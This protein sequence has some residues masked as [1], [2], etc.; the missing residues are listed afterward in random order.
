MW[1]WDD[2]HES[3]N[4]TVPFASL[5]ESIWAAR[6]ILGRSADA[7]RADVTARTRH[8]EITV[9]LSPPD[10]YSPE[11]DELVQAPDVYRART[12]A[13][14]AT[15]TLQLAEELDRLGL[16]VSP[17]SL[18][19]TG[20]EARIAGT[21]REGIR[22]MPPTW[23]REREAVSVVGLEGGTYVLERGRRVERFCDHRSGEPIAPVPLLV[24]E[25][26]W[27]HGTEIDVAQ[28]TEAD[29]AALAGARS[30]V[31]LVGFL[32]LELQYGALDPARAR[33]RLLRGWLEARD[34]LSIEAGPVAV[35]NSQRLITRRR[36]EVAWTPWSEDPRL[37][38]AEPSE[39]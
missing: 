2:L 16:V 3:A 13:A 5:R 23:R 4:A 32:A 21:R 24:G 39:A 37:L 1:I 27:M 31:D 38:L 28:V 8:L 20:T 25:T 17:E 34:A 11:W 30:A 7:V 19:D 33:A 35:A 10:S 18:R 9:E 6:A 26:Y 14:L 29:V 15:A 36:G 12:Q 22:A